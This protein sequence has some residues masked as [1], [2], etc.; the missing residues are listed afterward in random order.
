VK[1]LAIHSIGWGNTNQE[2]AVDLW[3]MQRPLREL[4]KHVDWQLDAQPTFI[5]GIEKYKHEKEFTTEELEKAAEYLGR[6][7]IVWSS[8]FPDKTAYLLMKV[9]S[10]RYGT[11]F[12]MDADDDLFHVN[13]DN[14]FW[15]KV[16]HPQVHDMQNM[17]RDV[18]WISTTTE[19][20]AD[21]FR[22]R[23]E[24]PRDTVTVLPNY[25]PDDYYHPPFDNKPWIVIGYFGGASH[26]YDLNDT[27]CMKAIKKLM[28]KYRNLRFK[29]INMPI[30]EGIPPKRYD[31]EDGKRGTPWI[32]EVFPTLKMDICIIPVKDNI[33]N[34]GKSNIKW[35]ESTRMGAAT[36]CSDVG[37][38]ALLPEGTT[39]KVKNHFYEWY[40][41]L[42]KL[43]V[44]EVY[45]GQLVHAAQAELAKHR[46]ED[47]WQEYQA[48]FNKVIEAK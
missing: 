35:M 8:Y 20:L 48:F 29:V 44:D 14:P 17:I 42:E 9:V 26:F 32:T 36:V 12:V 10:D 38:Y 33:F 46:L 6:Y 28:R 22:D 3:R 23:R 30:A 40:E 7:D 43:I 5:K 41:A 4:A 45:R 24:Q 31:F 15:T 18:G 1:I 16:G 21:T 27:K 25:M 39:I 37:P 34:Y 19:A 11:K 2:S 13:P 47:H